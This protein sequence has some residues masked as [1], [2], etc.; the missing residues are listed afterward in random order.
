MAS[1]SRWAS[2]PGRTVLVGV[3]ALLV[4]A[5]VGSGLYAVSLSM[6]FGAAFITAGASHASAAELVLGSTSVVALVLEV[7]GVTLAG[8]VTCVLA[9]RSA[10]IAP[11]WWPPLL[12]GLAVGA[13]YWGLAIAAARGDDLLALYLWP[14]HLASWT[15]LVAAQVVAVNLGARRS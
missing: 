7:L 9:T 4:A 2:S 3:V 14:T 12:A 10:T 5:L 1:G 8:A 11:R 13:G 6:V 15:W